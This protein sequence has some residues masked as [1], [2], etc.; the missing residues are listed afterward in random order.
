MRHR[1]LALA[2]IAALAAAL[3]IGTHAQQASTPPGDR[4]HSGV[5]LVSLDVCIKDRQ[6]RLAPAVAPGDLVVLE[7]N[8]P[9]PI[10][11]VW[12]AGRVPVA[13]TLLLDRSSS[14]EGD[15]IRYAREAAM[16]FVDGLGPEDQLS[17]IAFGRRA[18]RLTSFGDDRATASAAILKADAAGTTALY[19]ALMVALDDVVR[20]RRTRTR[21]MRDVVLV[22]TDGDDT[23][24][25]NAFEDVQAEARRQDVLVYAVA[26][27]LNDAPAPGLV[28]NLAPP[29][30][31]A[32]LATESGGLAVSAPALAQLPTVF[33][34]VLA[35]VTHLYRVGYVSTNPRRDGAW[36]K[37]S[38]R[39]RGD[40][41][42]RTRA[43]YLA[44]RGPM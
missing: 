16:R 4:F 3:P 11:F 6:G 36:R 18:E 15:P 24:S 8:V 37:V 13:V 9:Q 26:I 29:W 42:A 23:S 5:D 19:D 10:S 34:D 12:A 20:A 39:V 17:I 25:I 1:L 38:V 7:D 14:M 35:E 2:S 32:E 44:P 43:G 21:E 33:D 22:L 31:L 30:A 27:R 40:L 41:V 28:R